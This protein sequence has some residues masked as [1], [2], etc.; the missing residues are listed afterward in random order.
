LRWRTL[1]ILGGLV[2]VLAVTN[3]GIW[4]REKLLA[5]GKVVILEL[6]PVDPRS[7]MQGDYMALNFAASREVTRLRLGGERPEAEDSVMGYEPDGY[8]MLQTDARGVGQ[9]LRIQPDTHPHTDA[10]VPLRYRI[11]DNSVR[12]VTNAY[13]FPEGQ[14][15]RYQV[16]KYGEL[17][18]AENG[19]ALLVRMLDQDLKPL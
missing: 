3:G 8:V 10:E 11:R 7:L 14:A 9:P 15:E 18:V 2:L 17:R 16:A 1:A 6:A 5:S 4:Q 13:F 19:E 12:I